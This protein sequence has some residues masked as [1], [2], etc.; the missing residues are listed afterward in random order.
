M[1]KI[2]KKSGPKIFITVYAASNCKKNAV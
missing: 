1:K 2:M